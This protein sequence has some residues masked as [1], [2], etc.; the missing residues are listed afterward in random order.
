MQNSLMNRTLQRSVGIF[1]LGAVG[2]FAV[3]CAG[4][5]S[6]SAVS[7]GD[8]DQTKPTVETTPAARSPI[9]EYLAYLDGTNLAP[10]ARIRRIEDEDVR[11][12]ELIA[13]C[14]TEQGFTY[15]PHPTTTATFDGGVQWRTDDPDWL[16][17]YGF[18]VVVFPG[19]PAGELL[20]FGGDIPGQTNPNT[21]HFLTLSAAEQEAYNFALWGQRNPFPNPGP[22]TG[23][24]CPPAPTEQDLADWNAFEAD[25][26]N[27]GCWRQIHEQVM[28]EN[29]WS[30]LEADQFAP[31]FEAIN[32]FRSN[33]A[34]DATEADHDWAMCMN[35]AGHPGYVRRPDFRSEFSGELE[36][37]SQRI[38]D[39]KSEAGE[40][41]WH[42]PLQMGEAPEI[43]GLFE[44]EV[45][46][47]LADRDCR[48]AVGFD[49]RQQAAIFELEAQFVN[50]HRADF[51]ALR[52]AAEQLG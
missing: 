28:A 40:Q 14:M 36:D 12:E 9:D 2:L 17:N 26:G 33:A 39:E 47:A 3:A 15:V 8:G 52:A 43:D 11:R 37:I 38:I 42:F 35:D 1:V 23:V 30:L 45:A 6:G 10:E 24:G 20:Q 51:E 22:C 31:L 4:G 29:P 5:G 34:L 49:A 32:N 48:I 44:R 41:I 25:S 27:W 21:Q 50:D 13:E 7:S 16:V 18:G 46:T 19:L